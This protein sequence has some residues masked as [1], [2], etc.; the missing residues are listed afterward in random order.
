[1][2]A[3]FNRWW[4]LPL[5]ILVASAL[6]SL[7]VVVFG[8]SFVAG[9]SPAEPA[10]LAAA[11][12]SE[13]EAAG[14]GG[15]SGALAT[16]YACHQERYQA[17]VR[18]SDVKAAFDEL[19]AEYEEN[20]FVRSTCHQLTHVIGRAAA[21]RYGDIPSA[22]GRG[23]H[24]CGTGY[25][26]GVMEAVVARTGA[27]KLQ[28]EADALCADLREREPHSD[29]HYACAHGLGHGF[30]ALHENELF[31]SLKA[32]E[33]LTDGWERDHCYA[34]V[35]MENIVAEDNP[36]HPSKYLKADQPLYP[37]TAVE[38]RHKHLCYVYQGQHLLETQNG[39]FG[40]A[41]NLCA[42]ADDAGR[43]ACY[44]GLGAVGASFG[45]ASETTD[46]ARIA[47]VKRLCM[48]GEGYEA[49]SN[50]VGGA[51]NDL[52]Y[53]Q[54]SATIPKAFCES[55]RNANL[56]AVCVQEI[57]EEIEEESSREKAKSSTDAIAIEDNDSG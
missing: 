29:Y 13:A 41:L 47:T 26:H 27:D 51:A 44:R 53:R 55:F 2:G 48:L 46:A 4:L 19:K 15:C 23:V 28:E 40:E 57:E 43:P 49:R 34:G 7:N 1:M 31:E 32:C 11:G 12:A 38:T 20:D 3:G 50:C 45:I 54:Q 8:P 33:A 22:Y 52:I 42:T 39:K 56:R 10:P 35:F 18:D 24:F 9:R 14:G 30:M 6:V 37:C 17:L 25:Y 16:D 5:G 21:E 36:S